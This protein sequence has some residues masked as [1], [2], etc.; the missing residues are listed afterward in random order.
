MAI[1]TQVKLFFCV[2]VK[3]IRNIVSS[4]VVITNIV[5]AQ[6][7]LKDFYKRAKMEKKAIRKRREMSLR[8]QFQDA[9]KRR[10]IEYFE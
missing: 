1:E 8:I 2:T 7:V 4:E 6:K 5:I 9:N 10:I 3:M